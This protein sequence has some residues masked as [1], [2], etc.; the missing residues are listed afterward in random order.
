[1][2][3]KRLPRD[4]AAAQLIH[5]LSRLGYEVVRQS[6]SH[7]RLRTARDGEHSIT[8]PFHNPLKI[9]TLSAILSDIALHH[10]LSR[11]EL[12]EFLGL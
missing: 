1:L 5:A 12:L 8:I 7:M 6:G 2:P 11:D 4:L 9:G 3:S 10:Q